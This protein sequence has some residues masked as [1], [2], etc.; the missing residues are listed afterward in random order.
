MVCASLN[1]CF[2]LIRHAIGVLDLSAN[3]GSIFHSVL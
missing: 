1:L 3:P 2:G